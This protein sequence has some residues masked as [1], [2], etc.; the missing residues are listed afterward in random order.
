MSE[1]P[2]FNYIDDLR[3]RADD[4]TARRLVDEIAAT[5]ERLGAL[6]SHLEKHVQ[7]SCD[8]VWEH[9]ETRHG[10]YQEYR[11]CKHCELM[12]KLSND[13]TYK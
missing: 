5:K 2:E 6:E 11:N 3:Y 10:S 13:G 1:T 7:K 8:H 4:K 9:W 12:Q